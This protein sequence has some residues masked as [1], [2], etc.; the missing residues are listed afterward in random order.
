M[1]SMLEGVKVIDL[2]TGVAGPR[3]TFFLCDLGA[4]VIKVEKPGSGDAARLFPPYKGD[5]SVP[6]VALNRGKR[7]ITLDLKQ[8]GGVSLFKELVFKSDVLVENLR[9]GVMER[10]GL[11]YA[12]LKKINP[13]LVMCAISGYGQYGPL[14]SQPDYDA[15][16]QAVSGLMNAAGYAK[17]PLLS[18]DTL[19]IDLCSAVY[20]AF[21]ICAALF[22]RE[23]TG[24]GE[25]LD[26]SKLDVAI[27]FLEGRFMDF[28]GTDNALE[29][30][31]NRYPYATPFDTFTTLDGHIFIICLGKKPFKG[32]CDA[33]DQPELSK[34][35]RFSDPDVRN[36]NAPAL[37]Q[38]IERWTQNH[39]T[40]VL[41]Q[42]LSA[43]GVP[44]AP[45]NDV[46]QMLQ[47]PHLA[48]RN[49]VVDLEQPGAGMIQI[50]G[51][52][53]KTMN[54]S[55][56]IRGA[57]PDLGADNRVILEKVLQKSPREIDAI[58]DSGV[59]GR[60]KNRSNRGLNGT[61]RTT[62]L[63]FEKRF[64]VA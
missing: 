34:D 46:K 57:A 22:A 25:Y 13:K 35:R 45:V 54:S 28:N 7:G 39:T 20:A 48:A 24:E 14:A 15:I 29:T 9:P 19:I 51:P 23:K 44:A 27:Q 30:K 18:A 41:L 6:F 50:F 16:I 62:D 1:R 33:M 31:G 58:L 43:K 11:S 47:H 12:Q 4:E 21:G 38:L 36:Q 42:K 8:H 40:D 10:L 53:L 37:K 3:C 63:F 60:Q 61:A 49:M 59:M 5:Q 26:I 32:L 64:T 2:T 56:K 52:A 17:G 55:V